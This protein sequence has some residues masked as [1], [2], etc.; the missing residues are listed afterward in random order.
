VLLSLLLLQECEVEGVDTMA[1][2][3]VGYDALVA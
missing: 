1:E 3:S 2:A